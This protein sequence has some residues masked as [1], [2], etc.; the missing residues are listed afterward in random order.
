M[1]TVCTVL[2]YRNYFSNGTVFRAG[3]GGLAQVIA[4]VAV[5]GGL[6]A[7]ATP[8]AFRR[9]GATRWP[10]VLLAASALV[11]VAFGLPYR[12]PLLLAAALLLAFTSQAL[13]ISVD[14]LVQHYIED[15]FRGRVFALYDML[16]N[17][18]LVVAAALTAAVLPEDGHSPTSV[19][20]IG[21][22]YLLTAAGYL[23]L[24]SAP[25]TTP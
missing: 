23:R 18:A 7:I 2:L 17:L 21:V 12:K 20:L 25:R 16:F 15:A 5:G 8:V 19:V 14:T 4:A 22:A 10:V 13:K 3:L 1:W 6:A 9:L 24:R 11:E